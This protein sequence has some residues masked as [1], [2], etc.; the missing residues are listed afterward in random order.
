[1]VGVLELGGATLTSSPPPAESHTSPWPSNEPVGRGGGC[2][3]DT[4]PVPHFF[5]LYLSPGGTA[6]PVPVCFRARRDGF[7]AVLGF[8]ISGGL[9]FLFWFLCFGCAIDVVLHI[10]QIMVIKSI[11]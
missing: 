2:S 6:L 10:F 8:I 5:Q 3:A 11:F 7:E 1:M 4:H 9:V